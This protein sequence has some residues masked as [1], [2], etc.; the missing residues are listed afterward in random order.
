MLTMFLSITYLLIGISVL[1]DLPLAG[2]CSNLSGNIF[3]IL[4]VIQ[5][6]HMGTFTVGLIA[7]IQFLTIIYGRKKVTNCKVLPV[8]AAL[9]IL[10]IVLTI[11]ENAVDITLMHGFRRVKISGSLCAV[12]S[13]SNPVALIAVVLGYLIP[14]TVTMV[15]SYMSHRKIKISVIE[16]HGQRA[17]RN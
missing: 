5:S 9:V 14:F 10:S 8:Y 3:L 16:M 4:A 7:T 2:D 12:G 11:L 17:Q 15:M 6:W 1:T 13:T